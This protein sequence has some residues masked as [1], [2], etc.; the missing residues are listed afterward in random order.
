MEAYDNEKEW[1]AIHSLRV[2]IPDLAIK[3]IML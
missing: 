1:E 2:Q 3:N